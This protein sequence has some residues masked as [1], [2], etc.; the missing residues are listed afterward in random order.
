MLNPTIA[1]EKNTFKGVMK[2]KPD[3]RSLRTLK[4]VRLIKS[5]DVHI[6]V[7]VSTEIQ[8]CSPNPCRNGG[9]CEAIDRARFRCDCKDTGFGGERC[10]VGMITTPEFPKLSLN[11]SS[12]PFSLKA[13]P[14]ESIMIS[15]E[16]NSDLTLEPSTVQIRKPSSS[17]NLVVKTKTPGLKV[18][19]YSAQSSDGTVF[20]DPEDSVVFVSPKIAAQ[21]SIYGRLLLSRED[22]PLGCY[23]HTS[24]DLSCNAKFVSTT[25][26]TSD[27]S[28]GIIH[29][30]G[31]DAIPVPISITG[32]DLKHMDIAREKLIETTLLSSSNWKHQVM[33]SIDSGQCSSVN[34]GRNDVLELI[35]H[36]SLTS[37]FVGI[38]SRRTPDWFRIGVTEDNGAFDINNIQ[39][40]VAKEPSKIA[41]F[42][43]YPVST[44]SNLAYQCPKIQYIIY[45]DSE[46]LSTSSE[47]GNC[48]AVDV[49]K[50]SAFIHFSPSTKT[51]LQSLQ[52]FKDMADKGL[53][54]TIESIA[55]VEAGKKIYQA[56]ARIWNGKSLIE[57]QPF[58]HNLWLEGSMM[59]AMQIPRLLQLSIYVQGQAFVQSEDLQEVNFD[60]HKSDID[61][62]V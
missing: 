4:A 41:P 19:S 32:I 27:V 34:I 47:R 57:L 5:S 25:P 44:F 3:K 36:S 13:H 46:L 30:Y 11:S 17:A 53:R 60:A 22:I 15:M 8:T 9:R 37:S 58:Q 48:F 56:A 2:H 55:F 20:T 28:T 43:Q 38:V 6:W 45:V 49:C 26:W 61:N 18:V 40:N 21:K 16:T 10:Q 24:K 35:D 52:L 29:L 59:W 33:A 14:S 12:N 23:E 50:S 1:S 42:S 54:V 62:T 51:Q 39:V 31:S 7:L